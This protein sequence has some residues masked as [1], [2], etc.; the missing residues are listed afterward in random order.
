MRTMNLILLAG[1]A[2]VA[3]TCCNLSA[4]TY[5]ITSQVISNGGTSASNA[6]C[7][8]VGT[9]KQ[10]VVRASTGNYQLQHGFWP[11]VRSLSGCCIG[12]RGNVDGDIFDACDISD[13]TYLG[14][15]LYNGG[16]APSCFSEADVY[17]DGSLDISD[18]ST[19]VDYLYMGGSAPP[20]CP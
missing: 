13:L 6:S 20:S 10:T 2:L 8:L 15:Y 11:W 5:T 19:L 7:S 14:D 12:L 17:V 1:V 3:M 18:Y 16:S 9:V 4:Q